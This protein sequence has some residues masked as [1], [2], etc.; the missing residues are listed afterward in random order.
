MACNSESNS[1]TAAQADAMSSIL[2]RCQPVT[3]IESCPNTQT[4]VACVGPQHAAMSLVAAAKVPLTTGV[5]QSDCDAFPPS[6][7]ALD[8]RPDDLLLKVHECAP[9]QSFILDSTSKPLLA[10]VHV[11]LSR[12]VAEV[13]TIHSS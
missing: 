3:S 13:T 6:S 12:D 10:V 2:L 9:P 11:K 5:S 1:T 7:A 8:P 4:V